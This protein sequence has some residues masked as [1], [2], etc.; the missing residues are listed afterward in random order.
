M[1]HDHLQQILVGAQ[2][3]LELMSDGDSEQGKKSR[4]AVR[5][6]LVEALQ[7]SRSLA[8]DL[9]P[10]ILH[11]G[12]L[13]AGLEWLVRWVKD[14]HGLEVELEADPAANPTPEDVRVLVFQ[15]VRELLFNVV[16]HA[17]VAA[18]RVEF[19][20]HDET[21]LRLVVEDSGRGFD[22]VEVMNQRKRVDG[23][24]GL[25]SVHERLLLMGGRMDVHSA[26]GAGARFT[27][28]APRRSAAADS[29]EL[30]RREQREAPVAT[31]M[32]TTEQDGLIR[33]LLVEDHPVMRE[34][35][36]MLLEREADM[37]VAGE[38]SDGVEGVE[39]ARALRPSVVLMDFS[40]P[41][42]D[43]VE[44]TRRI[45]EEMPEISVIG[46]SMYESSERAAAMLGAGAVAY[47]EK[48]ADR[49]ELLATIRDVVA[50]VARG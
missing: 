39:L 33:I 4:I 17:G 26:P 28:I 49:A 13:A 8:V 37:V 31:P 27:L 19:A 42:M 38:A 50:S 10:P 1:L 18:A 46:L 36:R 9:F 6:A 22:P 20:V 16:K 24:F 21:F 40:M 14:K 44:A 7:V 15:S 30:S 35:L 23:G 34:G 29:A 43:G 12:G 45:H 25:L 11:E 3:R 47:R 2:M 41:G 5:H 32:Q 48:S